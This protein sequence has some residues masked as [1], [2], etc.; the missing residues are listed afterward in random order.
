MSSFEKPPEFNTLRSKLSIPGGMGGQ[1]SAR[2]D[3]VRTRA[4]VKA[5]GVP[6]QIE[7]ERKFD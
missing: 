7:V 5:R 4:G 3:K 1:R 2:T 6:R